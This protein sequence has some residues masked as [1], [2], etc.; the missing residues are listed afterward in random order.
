MYLLIKQKY[1]DGSDSR[2]S[3]CPIYYQVLK[4]FKWSKIN[5]FSFFFYILQGLKFLF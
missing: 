5:M 4:C 2:T 3:D 1:V